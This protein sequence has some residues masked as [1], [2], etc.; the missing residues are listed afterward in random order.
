MGVRKRETSIFTLFISYLSCFCLMIIVAISIILCLVAIAYNTNILLPANHAEKVI[1]QNEAA[2]IEDFDPSLLPAN[3]DH[4]LVGK[5]KLISSNLSAAKIEELKN[6]I[7]ENKQRLNIVYKELYLSDGSILFLRYD[8]LSHFAN[9]RLDHLIPNPELFIIVMLFVLIVSIAI[10]IG[11]LFAKKLRH[12][13]SPLM[14]ATNNIQANNLDFTI[15]GTQVHEFNDV[16]NAIDDLKA[17]LSQSLKEKWQKQQQKNLEISALCHD[18]KTPLTIIKGNVELLAESKDNKEQDQ[19]IAYILQSVDDID[20]YLATLMDVL[21]FEQL[22][23]NKQ[24]VP[25]QLFVDKLVNKLSIMCKTQKHQLIPTLALAN[26]SELVLDE[27]LIMRCLENIVDNALRYA[28]DETPILLKITCDQNYV[29]FTIEDQG[30]GFSKQALTYA[31]D[32]FY[33]D[34]QERTKRHYGLGLSFVKRVVSLH[35]GDLSLANGANGA[36]VSFT[37]PIT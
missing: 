32:I 11:Y 13:L 24:S 27:K 14:S 18:I 22:G 7:T 30:K 20:D 34:R 19:L 17:A 28:K 31:V 5:G 36:I 6:D 8:I 23:I 26:L 2:I 35:G 21:T 33:C 12:N 16:L 9:E 25:I 37:L 29:T 1:L 10:L 3:C 4:V 15:E